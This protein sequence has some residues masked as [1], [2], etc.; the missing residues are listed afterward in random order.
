MLGSADS[1]GKRGLSRK[2]KAIRRASGLDAR[3][4]TQPNEHKVCKRSFYSLRQGLRVASG[5]AGRVTRATARAYTGAF[6]F[7]HA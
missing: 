3:D 1:G 7:K 2:F 5:K 6:T 4:D